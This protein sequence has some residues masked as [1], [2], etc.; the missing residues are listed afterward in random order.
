MR[1]R[2]T[3]GADGDVLLE[4]PY[5]E[6]DP[7]REEFKAAI[8]WQGRKWDG[9]AKHWI[10]RALYVQELLT[11]L[12][13]HQAQIQ[14]DRAS[15]QAPIDRPAMP[16]DLRGAFAV[17]HLAPSAPSCVAEAAYKALVKYYHPDVGGTAELFTVV[18]DAIRVVR[19]YLNPEK[20]QD[21]E[22]PF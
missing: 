3:D 20:D 6:W 17:L 4:S 1:V 9:E 5:R 14:D 2:L 15:T 10:I 13:Q 7:V 11:F 18:N 21:D 8:P 12:A 16:D 19:F 22:I